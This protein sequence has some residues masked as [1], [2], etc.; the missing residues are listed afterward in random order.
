M[1]TPTT[2]EEDHDRPISPTD[3]VKEKWMTQE[4]WDYCSNKALELFAFG[5]E[6]AM[7]NGQIDLVMNT[8]E[9]LQAVKDS[10]EIRS[11]ALY[12]KIPYF[13]TA[14]AA[15]AAAHAIQSQNE[16]DIEVK[17]LQN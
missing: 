9:G 2:K 4:D 17:S 6:T 8:T 16:G 11:V 7:K 14:A 15:H 10:R 12:D 13:T 5:Q 1:L 3:I